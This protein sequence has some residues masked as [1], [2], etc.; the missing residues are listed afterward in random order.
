MRLFNLPQQVR[1]EV[2]GDEVVTVV[3]KEAQVAYNTV[4]SSR[5]VEGR[6]LLVKQHVLQARLVFKQRLPIVTQGAPLDYLGRS[7]LKMGLTA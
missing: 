4:C 5:S 6:V 7:A 3:F 1:E 2:L